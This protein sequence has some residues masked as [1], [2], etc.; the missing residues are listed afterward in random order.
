MV[1]GNKYCKSTAAELIKE[2]LVCDTKTFDMARNYQT[3]QL[4]LNTLSERMVNAGQEDTASAI[5]E[6]SSKL[7]ELYNTIGSE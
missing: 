4:G 6:L 1:N 2:G 3:V 5:L 7:K